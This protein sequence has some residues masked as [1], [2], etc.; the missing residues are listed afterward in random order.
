MAVSTEDADALAQELREIADKLWSIVGRLER[1][2]SPLPSREP[3][4]ELEPEP[5]A[6]ALDAAQGASDEA[7][8]EESDDE[9]PCP[10]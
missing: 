5:E 2:R 10:F 9:D 6:S 8:G 4:P 3:E 1:G 7:T